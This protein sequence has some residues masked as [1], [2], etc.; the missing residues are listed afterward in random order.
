M[1]FYIQTLTFNGLY[2]KILPLLPD[3]LNLSQF[4]ILEHSNAQ[5]SEQTHT[6]HNKVTA[7]LALKH[8]TTKWCGLALGGYP[9]GRSHADKNRSK[10]SS[11]EKANRGTD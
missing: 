4:T 3:R 9:K 6:H 10:K 11:D 1:N 8:S 2:V 5:V 7:P